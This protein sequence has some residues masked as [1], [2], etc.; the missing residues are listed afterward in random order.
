MTDGSFSANRP[1]ELWAQLRSLVARRAPAEADLAANRA[2]QREETERQFREA[3][4]KL[5]DELD[6]E[7]SAL[8]TRYTTARKAVVERCGQQH[9]ALADEYRHARKVADE[10]FKR[11]EVGQKQ[12]LKEARWEATTVFEATKDAP[13]ARLKQL[14]EDLAAKQE[15]LAALRGQADALLERRWQRPSPI[16]PA[17]SAAPAA[18]E[19][20]EHFAQL[21]E[22]ANRQWEALLGQRIA[23]QFEEGRP[24]LYFF[25]CW[26]VAIV[27]CGAAMGWSNWLWFPA[28]AVAGVL[29]WGG[30]GVWLYRLARRQT[31]EVHAM[32]RQTAVDAEAAAGRAREA[33][34]AIC[35]R[36]NAAI[37]QRLERELSGATEQSSAALAEIHARRQTALE[38]A[39]AHYPPRLTELI[40]QRE[41][42]LDRLEEEYTR[43]LEQ[44]NQ[45]R[46]TRTAQ[47][48]SQYSDQ[49]KEQED[50]YRQAWDE[51]SRNWREGMAAF[52][53][54]VDELNAATADLFLDWQTRE[55]SQWK[56]A[57]ENPRAVP[58]G[59]VE[60]DL[61]RLDGGI[62]T[63]ERLRPE[64]TRFTLPAL[65][66]F[67]QRPVVFA[68]RDEGRARAVEAIQ[69]IMLRMLTAA[70]PGKVR[71]TVID[72]VGLG[73]SFSAFMHLADFDE[74]IITS[75]IWT[76]SSHVEQRLVDLT[77][78]MENVIQVYL[79]NEFETIQEYNDFAGEM[80]EPFRVL[81][82][83]NF[84]ANFTEASARRLVSIVAS[85]ARCG[86]HGLISVD[87]RLKLPHNFDLA[88]LESQSLHLEWEDG[89]FAWRDAEMA[90]L[91]LEMER[92]PEPRTFTELVRVVG[93]RLHE[94]DRV[95]VPFEFVVPGEEKWWR[96]DAA[97]ELV[98]PL[99][100]AGAMK[101]QHLN[102]GRGTAQHVLVA[103]KTGSGK[104][105]LLHAIV[106]SVA[107]W[108]GPD[109]VELYLVDFK[110]GVEFKPYAEFGLPHA[111]VVAVESE[112][113]FGLSV[114]EQLDAELKR[115]G[116]L[117]RQRGVQDLAGHRRA[118]PDEPM[119]RVLLVID[120]FQELF[121]ED[122]RL[123]QSAALLLD[124][125]VRQG[126]AFGMHVLLGSQTLAG[127]YSLPRATIGQ[128]AVRIA[129]QCSE[130]D[131]HLILSEENTAARLLARPGEAIYN[132]ANGLYEGNHPFQVVWLP[133]HERTAYLERIRQ[134]AAANGCRTAPPIVFE[135]NAAADPAGNRLLAE[136]LAAPAWPAPAPSAT[137]WL[138]AAVA[139]KDPTSVVFQ[140]QGGG[141]LLLVGHR[142]ES[143]LGILAVA[144]LGLAAQIPPGA[145][146]DAPTFVVLDG[147]R[148]DAPE[149]GYWERL[150]QI[151]PQGICLATPRDMPEAIAQVTAE[152]DRRHEQGV[153]GAAPMFLIVH[154]LGRFRDLR[155][156]EETFRFSAADDD[157]P[158]SPAKQFG[159]ILRDGP[160]LGIHALVW[161]DTCNTLG[162]W[163]ERQAIHDL[164][165]RVAFQMSAG[166]SS[167]LIDSADA[168]RLGAHRAILYDEGLGQME[169]FR[170]Y[171]PP[172][173]TW[174]DEAQARFQSRG[175]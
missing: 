169:K 150:G 117:F 123:A 57:A 97:R 62:P 28:S 43:Q 18:I 87:T 91:P 70:R 9:A 100:R 147:T 132:D 6:A 109:Q 137:A 173:K 90:E 138:G 33:A 83:A 94:V 93:Q 141:N 27:P 48:E 23:R 44:W 55:P 124:R 119:P 153:E 26:T 163:L 4:R 95:E 89:R 101:L 167:T 113:E 10:Q 149:A 51:L 155:R 8:E 121:V 105:N 158:P 130:A 154:D 84:P 135:G 73:E 52:E 65:V 96:G 13:A 41:R 38:E 20:A 50:D 172:G 171:A 108:Y 1:R 81:V 129:L 3:R 139:I 16:E 114:L 131:A 168:G 126:R 40:V 49:V 34:R 25:L 166:D 63:D 140:R 98:V 7:R 148:P 118:R 85:G 61:A 159:R 14:E 160:P 125:L 128:M 142:E 161:C 110:K 152:L 74:Q 15:E 99:G 143:A 164:E 146:G 2:K 58:F 54:G 24:V 12:R 19:P 56:P 157:Q 45:A 36:E 46:A 116:D 47:L 21:V 31:A 104:S 64:R 151:V 79:R 68:A 133:D 30:L 78:H 106:T 42:E 67:P 175:K 88:D 107:L 156:E 80:A 120:E 112:R 69:A 92:P 102:L 170:P 127:A 32:L 76:E 37:A 82:V 60:V 71:F 29:L 75:R 111:R 115:R 39:D 136:A 86:V 122:D 35:Q 174:L 17:P 165:K 5:A 66:P 103:G 59:R 77:E 145:D 162:R 134:W 144:V 22:Q 11:A 53:Q 72:P